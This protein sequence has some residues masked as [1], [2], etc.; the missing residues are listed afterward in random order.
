MKNDFPLT[1]NEIEIRSYLPTGWGLESAEPEG[2]WDAAKSC[3]RSKVIDGADQV[4]PLEV[5]SS[6]STALGRMEALRV[7]MDRVHRH[8]LGSP[9]RGLGVG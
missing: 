2:H 9:T 7:A 8:R 4:W 6:D 5:K 1:Y 3:W